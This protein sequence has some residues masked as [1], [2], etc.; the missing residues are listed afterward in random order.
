MT[1][2]RSYFSYEPSLSGFSEDEYRNVPTEILVSSPK[3]LQCLHQIEDI[4]AEHLAPQGPLWDFRGM[5]PLPP[6]P[7]EYRTLNGE[8]PR[9]RSPWLI[10][11]RPK[12]SV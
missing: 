8:R 11:F 7:W 9:V 5:G 3:H 12:R 2:P 1:D 10:D 6:P 4:P